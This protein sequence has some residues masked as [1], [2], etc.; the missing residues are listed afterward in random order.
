MKLPQQSAFLVYEPTVT[1]L[2]RFAEV[3]EYV[4]SLH[5]HLVGCLLKPPIDLIE[6][7]QLVNIGV[8]HGRCGRVAQARPT[9]LAQSEEVTG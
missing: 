2:Y 7:K 9:L 8:V 6:Q 3:L 4:P 5:L 1:G